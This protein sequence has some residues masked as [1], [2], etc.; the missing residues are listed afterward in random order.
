LL[1]EADGKLVGIR[2]D[3]GGR[4]IGA[5]SISAGG[6]VGQRIAGEHG[7]DLRVDGDL[8]RVGGSVGIGK[9]VL[10]GALGHGW[11]GENLRC[12][13]NLAKALIL[14]EVEGAA[15][16]VI[17]AGQQDGTA[18]GESKLVSAKVRNAAR[19]GVGGVI[20]IVSRVEGGVAQELKE[21]TVEA[22]FA[23]SRDDVG[24]SGGAA[25]DFSRHPSGTGLDLLNGI[26]VEIGEGAAAH[27][28][29]ADVG[30][31]HGE[32][33]LDTA[34]AVDGELL[35]EVGGAVDV[36]HG[37]GGEEQEGAEVA[38]VERQLAYGLAGEFFASGW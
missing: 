22:A 21:G 32:D 36:G 3:I 4:G 26:D 33:R 1:V 24:E 9:G 14:A 15:A 25:S 16:T 10:T 12:S 38:P 29:I 2:V 34:L 11:D 20:E 28:G 31:V 13:E 23:G 19:L 17:D 18:V 8:E 30:S 27:F 7:G 37:S 35:G 6:I 5:R